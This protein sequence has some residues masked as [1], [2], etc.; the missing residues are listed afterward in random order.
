MIVTAGQIAEYLKGTVEG[1]PDVN[2]YAFARI[3]EGRPGAL[4]FLSNPIYTKYIYDCKSDVILV[5]KDF[6]AEKPITATLVRVDNAYES[7]AKLFSFVKSQQGRKTGI[8]SLSDIHT[9]AKIGEEAYIGPFVQIDASVN[10][11]SKPTI[12][13]NVSIGEETKI[14]DNVI[15]YPG[16]RIYPETIIGNN[17]ILHANAVIGSDGFGF[18]PTED[19]SYEK[20]PQMGT[21]IIKDDVE[22]GANTTIDRATLGTTVIEKGVKIDN[23]VQVAHNVSIGEH[24]VI[25]SQTGIAGSTKIG[26]K[27]MFGGQVGVSGHLEIAEG[28][29]LG[30][31]AGVSGNIRKPNQVMS[32]YPA[33]PMDTFRR[34]YVVHKNLP[35]LQKTIFELQKKVKELEQAVGIKTAD[36]DAK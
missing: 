15:I 25:A 35:E 19:G 26:K 18:A 20:I 21:V 10:I 36:S 27:A 24:S 11:G 5:N 2:V 23:L 14:G 16:V 31:K 33:I 1:N 12:Y 9:S 4:S 30:A 3:E 13:G 7:L 29:I 17:C 22:I 32:G 28:T 8:S 6:V 34:A